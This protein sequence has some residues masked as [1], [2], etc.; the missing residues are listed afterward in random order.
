MWCTNCRQDVPG[1]AP[2]PPDGT[3]AGNPL[4]CIRC[5]HVLA[6][7][8]ESLEAAAPAAIPAAQLDESASD[9][10]LSGLPAAFDTWE[11]EQRLRRIKRLSAPEEEAPSRD[12]AAKA[13]WRIDPA[14]P[15]TAA[16][17]SDSRFESEGRS[18][19]DS[20][21]GAWLSF[22]AWSA[23]AAGVAAFTCGGVLSGWS[24]FAGRDDLG[25]IGLPTL[26]AGQ[27]LLVVGL[28]LQLQAAWRS[29]TVRIQSRE[30]SDRGDSSS[31]RPPHV[32]DG[33]SR[34]GV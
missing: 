14:E 17:D 10:A 1:I 31:G 32:R 8:L 28:V 7:T 34:R 24:F 4:T 19:A 13:G 2:L 33:S 3:G 18:I 27:L 21:G 25:S 23:L 16:G 6:A 26:I 5:G 15:L 12:M 11:F 9:G 30:S 22:F 20:A 29:Q